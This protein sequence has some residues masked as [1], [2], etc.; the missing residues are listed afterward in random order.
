M[1]T[2]LC[3][4]VALRYSDTCSQR[5]TASHTHRPHEDTHAHTHYT[6]THTL[7][8]AHKLTFRTGGANHQV[9]VQVF[10]ELVCL[11]TCVCERKRGKEGEREG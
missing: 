6:R 7:T 9:S 3:V 4:V 8:H 11:I 1:R 5:I 10:E 2:G